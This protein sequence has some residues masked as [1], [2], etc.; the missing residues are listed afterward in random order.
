MLRRILLSLTSFQFILL[1]LLLLPSIHAAETKFYYR[2]K[3]SWVRNF[4]NVIPIDIHGDGVDELVIRSGL[5]IDVNDVGLNN[6]DS[7]FRISGLS[8]YSAIP[9]LPAKD[10]SIPFLISTFNSDSCVHKILLPTN[11]TRGKSIP[12]DSLKTFITFHRSDSSSRYDYLESLAMFY[13]YKTRSGRR[14]TLFKKNTHWDPNGSRGLIAADIYTQ[15]VLWESEVASVISSVVI[16]DIDNDDEIEI[17]L[18][19]Y[20]NNNGVSGGGM[21]DD[22]S[23]V[24]VLEAD[25]TQKWRRAI[26]PYWTGAQVGV[27][28]FSVDHKKNL[29]VYQVSLRISTATQDEIYLLNPVTGEHLAPPK[30][31]GSRFTL[32]MFPNLNCCFDFNGDRR[33]EIVVGGTDGFVRLL[34]GELNEIENSELFEKDYVRIVA[35]TDLDGNGFLEVVCTASEEQIVILDHRLNTLCSYQ[36]AFLGI[37]SLVV[38][39]GEKNNSLLV[40]TNN[41]KDMAYHLLE[42]EKSIYPFESVQTIKKATCWG[43]VACV[44]VFFLIILRN[45]F[46]GARARKLLPSLLGE[47][48]LLDRCLLI[49]K[50][51]KLESIGSYWGQLFNVQPYRFAGQ[52]WRILFQE[53]QLKPIENVLTEFFKYTIIE[54][55]IRISVHG[56]GEQKAMKLKSR[57]LPNEK[58]YC[59]MIFDMSEEEHIRQVKH[60]AQVAQRLAHG[61][62]NPLTTVKLNAE[63]LRHVLEKNCRELIPN[64]DDYFNAMIHQVNKLK[65]MSDG[66]MQFVEFEKP[67]LRPCDMNEIIRELI[68][69]WQPEKSTGIQIEMELEEIMSQTLLDPQQFEFALK[70]VFFNAVESIPEGGRILISSRKVTLLHSDNK[71]YG[72][73]EFN[74][75]Q[76]RDT[77][78]G[79]P[80][81]FLDKV[82][83][84]YFTRNK[85]EG[86]GLGLSIV[87]KIIDSHE[88]QLE[89]SSEVDVGTTATLRFRIKSE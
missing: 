54:R 56:D 44:A 39:N 32:P 12:P 38:V 10:G 23:Y 49:T 68:V 29:I 51:G 82:C 2:L 78:C 76:V 55:T 21:A 85:T 17:I 67:H 41:E 5:Q 86:T 46:F 45:L 35:V 47:A 37:N 1:N 80:P 28:N 63:E 16:D 58:T 64:I 60:W 34:D 14:I 24:I 30:K 69:L 36:F 42:F 15:E 8:Q 65:K 57:Y 13:N 50:N 31:S 73:I 75:L 52:H 22:S 6:Y 7:S 19:T 66:F 43:V 26:G 25:G 81:E 18:G 11:L 4:D 62:K 27:G 77:G 83:K 71:G 59:V 3:E 48:D 61:I 74:E 72:P 40:S 20:A 9:L 88:G 87:Q 70:N 79:I 89:I 33:D 53:D 84:P